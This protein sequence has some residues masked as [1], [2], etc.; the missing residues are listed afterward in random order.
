MAVK[1]KSEDGKLAQL[2]Y[3]SNQASLVLRQLDSELDHA[4]AYGR[5]AFACPAADVCVAHGCVSA[6]VSVCV[7]VCVR[8]YLCVCVSA[9]VS[10]CVCVSV[11]LSVCLSA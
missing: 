4:S 10:V 8:A 2:S 6:C 1:D 9:C 3:G 7:C 11:C 5:V